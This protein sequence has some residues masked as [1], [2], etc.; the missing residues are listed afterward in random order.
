MTREKNRIQ[1]LASEIS[2]LRYGLETHMH[3]ARIGKYNKIEMFA[4]MEKEVNFH[5]TTLFFSCSNE[6]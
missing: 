5:S 4:G 1:P 6:W 3:S 2:K